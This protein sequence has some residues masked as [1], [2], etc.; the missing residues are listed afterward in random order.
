MSEF[1]IKESKIYCNKI[2]KNKN[3]IQEVDEFYAI[4][5]YSN[6]DI[7]IENLEFFRDNDNNEEIDNVLEDGYLDKV[8]L[9]Y[10]RMFIGRLGGKRLRATEYNFFLLERTKGI[11]IRDLAEAWKK[12]EKTI[13]DS[14]MYEGLSYVG[15]CIPPNQIPIPVYEIHIS[16]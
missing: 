8:V 6:G 3:R 16:I 15:D 11:R 1:K 10:E 13:Y 9:P 7:D 4:Q 14:V 12:I 2:L 5:N